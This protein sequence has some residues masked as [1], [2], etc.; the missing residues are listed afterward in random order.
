M[1]NGKRIQPVKGQR[2]NVSRKTDTPATVWLVPNGE[3][4]DILVIDSETHVAMR[5]ERPVE[6]ELP[7][8]AMSL[9]PLHGG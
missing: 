1:S 4:G 5:L 3:Q 8:D 6:I 9:D 2:K 7:A